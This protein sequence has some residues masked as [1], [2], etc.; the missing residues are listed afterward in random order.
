MK[1]AKRLSLT[2]KLVVAILALVLLF[3]IPFASTKTTAFADET[4]VYYDEIDYYGTGTHVNDSYQISYDELDRTVKGYYNGPSLGLHDN[5]LTN[6]CATLA[7]ANIV[8]F[9]DRFYTDLIPNYTPGAITPYGFW[10]YYPDQG[11]TPTVELVGTLHT[12]MNSADGTTEA[13]FKSGLQS[14]ASSKGRSVSYSSFYSSSVNVNLSALETAFNQNKVGL[15]MCSTYNFVG[16]ISNNAQSKLVHVAKHNSSVGHMMMVYGYEI[17]KYYVGGSLI[18]TDTFLSV[19]S[20]YA[21]GAKGYI[22]LN[23]DL[24]IEQAYIVTIS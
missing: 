8:A 13:E 4:V 21:D 19:S 22:L 11:L 24:T 9:Y 1:N 2:Q 20:G 3:V 14:F 18:R 16:S 12:L 7:G 5:N 6:A 23:D 10:M 15:L 17:F